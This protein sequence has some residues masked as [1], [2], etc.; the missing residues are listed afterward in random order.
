M[1]KSEV[2]RFVTEA[3]QN[4]EIQNDLLQRVEAPALVEVGNKHGFDFTENDVRAFVAEQAPPP[5][6]D[7]AKTARVFR[8]TN[9]RLP[10]PGGIT[11]QFGSF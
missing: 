10:I 9:V 2:E 7:E 3:N 11:G 1:S 5:S 4:T 6:G 8:I